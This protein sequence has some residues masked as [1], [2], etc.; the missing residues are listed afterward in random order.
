VRALSLALALAV[1]ACS[2]A[3][4]CPTPETVLVPGAEP[5]TCADAEVVPRWSTVLASRP[6]LP[7]QHER[8]LASLRDRAQTD[9]ASVLAAVKDSRAALDAL[10]GQQ[11]RVAAEARS[12]AL[13]DAE[14]GLGPLPSAR[15]PDGAAAAVKAAAVWA[16]DDKEKLALS[17][18]DIEGWI[19]YASLCREA[20]GAGPL[21]VSVQGRVEV[22]RVI[23]ERW[24][25]A[26]RRGKIALTAIGPFWA[27][28]KDAWS[29]ASYD[30]QQTWI[31]SA[32]LPPPMTGTSTQYVEALLKTDVA[33]HA[34]VLHTLL[35]PFTVWGG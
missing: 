6:L 23:V 21:A 25:A 5:V 10:L 29:G 14:H 11:D 13:Y 16:F 12:R 18:A 28:A 15:F 19:F 35:G 7:S 32:P 4:V 9:P 22:Y 24:K 17:E 27:G 33:E 31:Q 1:G 20:Q 3:P 34:N 26:D 2:T 8:I 30:M